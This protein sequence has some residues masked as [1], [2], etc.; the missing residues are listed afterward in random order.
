MEM[1]A[2]LIFANLKRVGSIKS[3]Y[4][5]NWE[6]AKAEYFIDDTNANKGACTL[7]VHVLSVRG[8]QAV[9]GCYDYDSKEQAEQAIEDLNEF[10]FN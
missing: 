4:S 10:Y 7:I 1:T 6:K 3:K 9:C 8:K 2:L 5:V